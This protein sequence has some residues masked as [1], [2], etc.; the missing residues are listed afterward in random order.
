MSAAVSASVTAVKVTA[1]HNRAQLL[2]GLEDAA[3]THYADPA[4]PVPRHKSRRSPS[5][6]YKY[7]FD[8]KRPKHPSIRVSNRNG[9]KG[10][11]AHSHTVKITE[12]WHGDVALMFEALPHPH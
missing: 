2:M 7:N 3:T 10:S 11:P 12:M 8:R 5:H 9:D 6:Q 4:I 1:L